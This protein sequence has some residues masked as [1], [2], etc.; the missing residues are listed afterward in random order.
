MGQIEKLVASKYATI[1]HEPTSSPGPFPWLG[2]EVG[3]EQQEAESAGLTRQ[4]ERKLVHLAQNKLTD[5]L[6]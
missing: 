6:H 4:P 5:V 3:D 1:R 2:N